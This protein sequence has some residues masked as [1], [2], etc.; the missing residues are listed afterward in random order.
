MSQPDGE[1]ANCPKCEQERVFRKYATKARPSVVDLHR[2]RPARSPDRRN[3]L[4]RI[5]HAAAPLVLRHVPDDEHSLRH[6]CQAARASDRRVLPDRTPDAAPDPRRVDEGRRHDAGRRCR[7]RRGMRR[8]QNRAGRQGKHPYL[9]KKERPTR[10]GPLASSK[11]R[12]EFRPT[13]CVE[14]PT[15]KV[16]P[17]YRQGGRNFKAWSRTPR[18]G[19]EPT[20]SSFE[21]GALYGLS[22]SAELPGP[23]QHTAS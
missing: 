11:S 10:G 21:V 14:T 2:V 7:G 4:P 6:F 9:N 15:S 1:L 20:T 19:F 16:R 5:I 13:L 22:S 3:N 18:V 12:P 8:R 17:V 23:A